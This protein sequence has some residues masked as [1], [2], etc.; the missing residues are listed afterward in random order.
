[1]TLH[2]I[3][4]MHISMPHMGK[5]SVSLPMRFCPPV[6]DGSV[7][8]MGLAAPKTASDLC[9]H[10]VTSS[11]YTGAPV[12]GSGWYT[13]PWPWQRPT[14]LGPDHDTS[15]GKHETECVHKTPPG[16]DLASVAKARRQG[17]P[18]G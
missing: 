14:P 6:S 7:R 5:V 4:Y 8:R 15:L 13:F 17:S 2:L 11:E 9:P 1:M 10:P 3:D 16:I 18:A 12:G